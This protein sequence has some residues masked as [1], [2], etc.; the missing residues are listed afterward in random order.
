[1]AARLV[2]DGIAQGMVSAGNA[3]AVMATAKMGAGVLAHG[4]STARLLPAHFPTL[5]GNSC[6]DGCRWRERGLLANMLAQFAV[7][8]DAYS[9]VIFDTKN[10]KVGLLSTRA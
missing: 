8:G 4:V 7:M 1:M 2:R 5:S 9:R 10:P 3:G 6:V